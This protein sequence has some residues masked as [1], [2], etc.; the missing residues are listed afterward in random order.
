MSCKNVFAV[1]QVTP[2]QLAIVSHSVPEGTSMGLPQGLTDRW[3]VVD[4]DSVVEQEDGALLEFVGLN[5]A[6]AYQNLWL[7][8]GIIQRSL[9]S[10]TYDLIGESSH[11]RNSQ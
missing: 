1:L 2:V 6:V 3:R 10:R 7:E 9:L 5:E 4:L 11:D 8:S